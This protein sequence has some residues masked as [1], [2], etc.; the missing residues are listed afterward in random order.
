MSGGGVTVSK[1]GGAEY[2]GGRGLMMS[3]CKG[4]YSPQSNESSSYLLVLTTKYCS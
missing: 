2:P 3:R 1:G 4:I